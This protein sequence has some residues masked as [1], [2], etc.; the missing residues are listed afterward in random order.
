M[1]RGRR[2]RYLMRLYCLILLMLQETL[3]LAL[4]LRLETVQRVHRRL[5]LNDLHWLL[6]Q[7]LRLHRLMLYCLL[8][9]LLLYLW[10]KRVLR[11]HRLLLYG[12]YGLRL[13]RLLLYRLYR[14]LL[15]RLHRL[16]DGLLVHRRLQDQA[17][18]QPEYALEDQLRLQVLVEGGV[19]LED[20]PPVLAHRQLE[21][22]APL[23][24]Q[25]VVYRKI[26]GY[27]GVERDA[28]LGLGRAIRE[29]PAL[30]ILIQHLYYRSGRVYRR[31]GHG[32][33]LNVPDFLRFRLDDVL[34]LLGLRSVRHRGRF[35]FA[36][37]GVALELDVVLVP[38][39]R[40]LHQIGQVQFLLHLVFRLLLHR[41]VLLLL[42]L[43]LLGLL[44]RLMLGVVDDEVLRRGC[45][46]IRH[47]R[48]HVGCRRCR[49]GELDA[50]G[51]DADHRLRSGYLQQGLSAR[52]Q[53]ETLR[54]R[55]RHLR[56]DLGLRPQD[57]LDAG[58]RQQRHL[59]QEHRLGRRH[60][61][62]RRLLVGDHDL[63]AEK[64]DNQYCK[65]PT[66]P[67]DDY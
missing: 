63:G 3:Q 28:G 35:A 49:G 5:R 31:L 46:R 10:L 4:N 52:L 64:K 57:E 58:R 60:D 66:T 15:Y 61:G 56:R 48:R 23:H 40:Q 65:R 32:A 47:L 21:P 38:Y 50:V 25:S 62:R 16:L 51:Q 67:N 13:Y 44:V 45:C 27:E 9:C 26:W 34:L 37:R 22:P 53:D 2:W 29:H 19:V 43:L 20:Q 18:V 30:E 42:R 6:H 39:S 17:P 41:L 33:Q 14:L 36:L 59:V 12:L 54:G 8:Y 55:R 24:H 7:R 1:K 11:L